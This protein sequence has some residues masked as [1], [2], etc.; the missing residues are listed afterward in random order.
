LAVFWNS[1]GV[2]TDFL[3]KGAT[4]NLER[5]IESLK[6]LKNASQGRGQ[7]LMMSCFN[8]TM[9][10]LAQVPPQLMPFHVC[11]LQCYHI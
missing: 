3:G 8:K 2:F 7:K 10:G 6:S 9:P 1:E 5:C 4:V 11:D